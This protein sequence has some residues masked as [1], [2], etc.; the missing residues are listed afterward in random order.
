MLEV[1]VFATGSLRFSGGGRSRIGSGNVFLLDAGS[2]G[3]DL[4]GR[5]YLII[6]T[7]QDTSEAEAETSLVV[8]DYNMKRMRRVM[9]RQGSVWAIEA[10]ASRSFCRCAVCSNYPA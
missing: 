5:R 8:P 3:V 6:A 9:G 10:G 7:D 2:D 4:S 1:L